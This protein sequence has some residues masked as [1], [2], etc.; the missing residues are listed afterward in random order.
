[1]M[2]MMHRRRHM[3]SSLAILSLL[4]LLAS[5]SIHAFT[6]PLIGKTV[7]TS[8][9][10]SSQEV[11]STFTRRGTVAGPPLDDKPDY[12]NIHGPLGKTLDKVFLTVFRSKMAEKI[13]VDSAL[14]K[15]SWIQATAFSL[16]NDN[17][18]DSCSPADRLC[19]FIIIIGRLPRLDGASNRDER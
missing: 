10:M 17:D 18:N 3:P 4:L 14:P 19:P 8:L 1:M 7:T 12:Q 15:V 2:T 5:E 16:G 6:P 9:C 13:G 11:N